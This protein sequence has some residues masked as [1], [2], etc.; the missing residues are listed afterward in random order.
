MIIMRNHIY[1]L[2]DFLFAVPGRAPLC[3]RI[4][5][6]G[7]PGRSRFPATISAVTL[8]KI[9]EQCLYMTSV[10]DPKPA[11]T[12]KSIQIRFYLLHTDT[13]LYS[14]GEHHWVLCELWRQADNCISTIRKSFKHHLH[15]SAIIPLPVH[16]DYEAYYV[17]IWFYLNV[18]LVEKLFN[19]KNAQQHN[20]CH[21]KQHLRRNWIN[22]HQL[23]RQQWTKKIKPSAQ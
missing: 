21:V 22:L 23:T 12:T 14:T 15:C 2:Y 13:V 18:F 11:A 10:G 6:P 1:V 16:I 4:C 20:K 19:F 5:T 17:L 7:C 9:I 8:V 3:G